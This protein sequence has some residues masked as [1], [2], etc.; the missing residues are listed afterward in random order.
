MLDFVA[1][2]VGLLDVG[3]FRQGLLDALRRAVPSDFASLNEVGPND[4]IGLAIPAIE[5]RLIDRFGELVRE[6]PLY[7][8]WIETHDGR[9]YR[10]SDVISREELEAREIYR[11]FYAPLGIR[12]QIAFTLPEIPGRTLALALSRRRT[13]Y[14]DAERDFLNRARPFVIQ[15]YRNALAFSA[16]QRGNAD[17]LRPALL[18]HG[19]TVREVDVLQRVAAG[20]SN[21]QVADEL[22]LSPRTIQKHLERIFRKLGVG[23]RAAAAARAWQLAAGED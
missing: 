6:N 23:T 5:P 22:D 7:E 20:G 12:H 11:D 4:F 13:D 15:A 9:A 19:L 3:E 10:F 1:E 16:L 14:S 8:R 18:R 2:L 21:R 17:L